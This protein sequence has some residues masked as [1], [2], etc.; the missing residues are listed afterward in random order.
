MKI[1]FISEL[2]DIGGYETDGKDNK[3]S[4]A[5]QLMAMR[6]GSGDPRDEEWLAMWP[7]SEACN[8]CV[9]R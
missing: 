6:T 5:R 1:D 4:V 2:R 7:I 3:S 9:V 8:F